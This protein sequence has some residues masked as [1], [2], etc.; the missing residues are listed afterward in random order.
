MKFPKLG[1]CNRNSLE[2][3]GSLEQP[4]IATCWLLFNILCK[5]NTGQEGEKEK[6]KR[7]RGEKLRLKQSKYSVL[8]THYHNWK[9]YEESKVHTSTNTQGGNL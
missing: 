1:K 3:G 2:H 4:C 9:S 7:E 5:H 8:N 6:G